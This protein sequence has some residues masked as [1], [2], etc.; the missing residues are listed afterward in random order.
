MRRPGGI[1][2]FRL[3]NNVS[4]SKG[5]FGICFVEAF[6]DQVKETLAVKIIKNDCP[7]GLV[8]VSDHNRL[9]VYAQELQG[10][11]EKESDAIKVLAMEEL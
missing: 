11:F 6:D 3:W 9:L 10:P 1:Y 2:I 5:P 7:G 8:Y 4:K